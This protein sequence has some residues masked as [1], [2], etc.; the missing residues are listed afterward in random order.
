MKKF[1]S[2]LLVIISMCTLFI[3]NVSAASEPISVD[4]PI[5]A[6]GVNSLVCSPTKNTADTKSDS[7]KWTGGTIYKFN[8]FVKL[9]NDTWISE[10]VSFPASWK[11][12]G[13][14]HSIEYKTGLTITKGTKYNVFAEQF[15]VAQK[16]LQGSYKYYN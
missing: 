3:L 14:Y 15:N 2:T 11:G 1:V 4:V 16:Q 8:M 10:K 9:A 6:A 5:S 12:D 13:K 7:F